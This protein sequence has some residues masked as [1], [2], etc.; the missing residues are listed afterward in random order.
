MHIPVD[1]DNNDEELVC[2]L[3]FAKSTIPGAGL[4]IFAG[5]DVESG[6]SVLPIGDVVIP[7]VDL[8]IHQGYKNTHNEHFLWDEYTWDGGTLFM[9]HEGLGDELNAASPGFGAAVNCF[10]DLVNVKEGFPPS[11]NLGLHR[12]TDPGAGAFSYYWNR[13][14]IASTPIQA[15]NELFASCK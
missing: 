5:K 7:L 10:M 3:W 14:S 15:G 1:N 2:G 11:N 8:N 6:T 12:S 4:G 13:D 9:D